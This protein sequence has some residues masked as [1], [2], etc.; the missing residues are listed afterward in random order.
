MAGQEFYLVRGDLDT[1]KA[2]TIDG[3]AWHETGAPGLIVCQFPSGQAQVYGPVT[4]P[5]PPDRHWFEVVCKP[6]ALAD[7]PSDESGAAHAKVGLSVALQAHYRNA[8]RAMARN[9]QG[10]AVA[11]LPFNAVAGQSPVM[12]ATGGQDPDEMQTIPGLEP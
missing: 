11:P 5:G 10:G 8:G 2:A 7:I 12:L 6:G 1:I 9:S 4:I 3:T